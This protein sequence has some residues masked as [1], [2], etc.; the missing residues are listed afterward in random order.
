[1]YFMKKIKIKFLCAD[2]RWTDWY[3]FYSDNWPEHLKMGYYLAV[4][5]VEQMMKEEYENFQKS[6][7][8]KTSGQS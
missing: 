5:I 2:H 6:S 7:T 3:E 8:P 1:M 4:R